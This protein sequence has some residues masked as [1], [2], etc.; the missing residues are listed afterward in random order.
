MKKMNYG[1]S[2]GSKGMSH[3]DSYEMSH[4]EG[5][6]KV[7]SHGKM[8]MGYMGMGSASYG[9]DHMV[10]ADHYVAKPTADSTKYSTSPDEKILCGYEGMHERD[11]MAEMKFAQAAMDG[12]YM[13]MPKL[14]GKYKG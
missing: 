11:Y 12:R 7:M 14:R 1:D 5:S 6:G 2:Y 10:D 9:Y 13:D 4:D 3:G 8:G